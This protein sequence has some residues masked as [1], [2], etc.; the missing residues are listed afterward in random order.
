MIM[1]T[2]ININATIGRYNKVPVYTILG[3]KNSAGE[4]KNSD[5]KNIVSDH[6]VGGL[7]FLPTP[8]LRITAEG[9]YKAYSNYP[10]SIATGISLANLG[11][12]YGAI[13]N[14]AVISSGKGKSYGAELFVQQKLTKDYYVTASYTFFYSK[15]SGLDGKYIA[16]TWDTRNLISL[17]VGKKFKKGWEL[18]IKYRLSGGAPYSPYDMSASQSTYTI[19][20]Q[21]V[22]DYSKLNS[23]RLPVFNQLDLRID[24]KFNYKRTTLNIYL[25][26]QNVLMSKSVSKDYYTFQRN[27][28]NSGFETTDGKVLKADG[29]NAIPL[30]IKNEDKTFIPA[31]GIIYQF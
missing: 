30:L 7:E 8:S 17:I 22:D 14:E 31:L 5:V 21:G 1:S 9:F 16:S 29:S 10:V 25:D 18:G 12:D 28:D 4:L 20:G 6:I 3:Y 13:G 26:F 19:A 15:F 11:D 24:K 27:A 23:E 2:K